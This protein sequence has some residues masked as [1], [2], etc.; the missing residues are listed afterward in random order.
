MERLVLF[1]AFQPEGF[2]VGAA[3][4]GKLRRL[5]R[6]VHGIKLF[7]GY[8]QK[9]GNGG[10]LRQDGGIARAEAQCFPALHDG[11]A[12][13]QRHAGNSVFR[14]HPG[15]RIEIEGLGNT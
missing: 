9:I 2:Q 12:E 7:L 11:F 1:G 4:K 14:L 15:K 8:L 13:A 6:E 5:S 10:S 3:T